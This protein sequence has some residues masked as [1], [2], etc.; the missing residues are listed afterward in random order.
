M[1]LARGLFDDRA[2]TGDY[3][4]QAVGK[5]NMAELAT[6]KFGIT[7]PIC[8]RFCFLGYVEIEDTASVGDLRSKLLQQGWK[9]EI[10][11]C[12]YLKCDGEIFCSWNVAVF[13]R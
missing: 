5:G 3:P 11:R 9:G 8:K 1:P 12:D 7:C 2:A 10:A 6:R 4:V 13:P